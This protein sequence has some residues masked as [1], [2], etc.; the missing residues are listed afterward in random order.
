[1]KARECPFCES[2]RVEVVEEEVMG[3]TV[4]RVRC[5]ACRAAGPVFYTSDTQ[6]QAVEHWNNRA[7]FRS[8]TEVPE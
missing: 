2:P 4:R 3:K 6:A 8:W 7:E 1:M 5:M